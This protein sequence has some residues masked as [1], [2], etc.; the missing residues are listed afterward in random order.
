MNPAGPLFDVGN[1]ATRLDFTDA[2][3]VEVIHTETG[4]FGIAAPIGH[5]NFYANGGANQPGCVRKSDS[6][7]F[8]EI[9]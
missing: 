1:P 3:Y 7:K 9:C 2:E 5:A 8:N 6:S 4:T